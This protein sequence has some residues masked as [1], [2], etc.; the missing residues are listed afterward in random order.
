MTSRKHWLGLLL[1][2]CS[3]LTCGSTGSG[4]E[5]EEPQVP[6]RNE[7]PAELVAR[8]DL[9]RF[10]LTL[11][12]PVEAPL[13]ALRAAAEEL[14]KR[15][16]AAT[17]NRAKV[18]WR[19][20]TATAPEEQNPALVLAVDGAA[21]VTLPA[22]QDAWARLTLVAAVDRA[23]SEAR[24]KGLSGQVKF[25]HTPPEAVLKNPEAHRGELLAQWLKRSRELAEA[26]Q[27]QKAPLVFTHCEP[28]PR[29]SVTPI[30][31]EEVGLSLPLS[32]GLEVLSRRA[33]G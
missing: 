30:S 16:G 10:N 12:A 27:S 26:A 24:A 19:G 5:Y 28:A 1:A 13:S 4:S 22:E 17:G 9:L 11:E 7:A 2:G 32:C 20:L 15:L 23:L 29:V 25:N 8:P 6:A 33:G 18:K 21:E 31:L 3:V 14:G